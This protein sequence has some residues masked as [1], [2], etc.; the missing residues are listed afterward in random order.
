MTS[1]KIKV[2]FIDF[3]A[4]QNSVKNFF[5]EHF[6]LEISEHPDFVIC[7]SFD[8][9]FTAHHDCVRI[10]CQTENIRPDFLKYDY[11]V[12]LDYPASARSYR[13]P[14]C[15]WRISRPILNEAIVTPPPPP[16]PHKRKFC[17]FLFSNQNEKLEGVR[18]RIAFFDKLSRYRKVDAGG[19]SRRNLLRKV[20]PGKGVEFMRK[21]KFTISFE[22]SSHPGYTSEKIL[23]PLLAGSIPIYWGNPLVHRDFNPKAF[24]NC[25]EYGSFDE[26]IEKIIE[27][28]NDDN[29]YRRY[30]SEPCL[31]D[32][33]ESEYARKADF[34]GW[35]ERIFRQK[36]IVRRRFVHPRQSAR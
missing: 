19:T 34:I 28:D 24:I 23:N 5:M 17:N 15:Y 18:K 26:V 21:Y 31:A 16:P 13:F 27:I 2:Q 32:G 33:I 1:Q 36:K 9:S 4:E 3:W 20:R 8:S 7:S 10:F 14:L 11:A 30:L 12:S 29:L 25:H 22:N 6:A 35:L